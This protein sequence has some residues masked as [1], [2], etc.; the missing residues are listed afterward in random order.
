LRGR[1]KKLYPDFGLDE[2]NAYSMRL[3]DAAGKNILALSVGNKKSG[4]SL[5]VRQQ[6]SENIYLTR[7]DFFRL[8]GIFGDPAAE[9]LRN[10][11]WAAGD[12]LQFTTAEVTEIEVK[13]KVNGKEVPA[14]SLK[15]DGS[16][17]VYTR[18]GLPFSPDTTKVTQYLDAMKSWRSQKVLSPETGKDY[19]FGKGE[20]QLLL[21][22]E[23]GKELT[24]QAGDSDAQT[25]ST[26][27]KSSL[28]PVIFQLSN[29]Y[30]ENFD[31]DDARFFPDNPLGIDVDKM[32]K[33]LIQNGKT[34]LEFQPSQKKWDS[35]KQYL[36]EL[37]VLHLEKLL[38]NGKSVSKPAQR[39]EI[40]TEGQAA[41]Q[42]IEVGAQIAETKEYPVKLQSAP[43][44]TFSISESTFKTLFENL[45]RLAEP[46]PMAQKQ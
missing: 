15:K 45:E 18:A 16:G 44:H 8:A 25:N 28:E 3:S 23:G 30:F 2:N 41:P 35:L 42:V 19:G 14:A 27:F 22:F 33:L 43:A 32:Q 40:Q 24:L 46:D 34:R 37:K 6:S 36:E 20:W 10:D 21:R 17:W 11:Y 26:Y 38:L 29:Y 4:Q 39:L 31:A 5:F 7:A 12:M 9:S 13:R 1:G